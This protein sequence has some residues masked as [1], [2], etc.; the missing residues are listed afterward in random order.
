MDKNKILMRGVIERAEGEESLRLSVSSE[1]PCKNYVHTNN[2]GI[3]ANVILEHSESAIEGAWIKDGIVLRDNH[4]GEVVARGIDCHIAD[5][6]LVCDGIVWGA[7]DR[8]QTI[9]ADVESGVIRDLSIEADY[10]VDDVE[11]AD[12]DLY[13]IRR[14]TPLAAAFVAIP[15]DP[16]VG[17]NREF[18]AEDVKTQEESSPEA[19]C[20]RAKPM[21]NENKEGDALAD[22][23]P[24]V[25][26][27]VDNS[28]EITR[29]EHEQFSI[30]RAIR[31]IV[32]RDPSIAK[33]E[34]KVSD[35]L[36]R[37]MGRPARGLYM[38]LERSFTTAAGNGAGLVET[39]H[40]GND[41]I[42][43]LRDKM[44]LDKL[45]VS[46]LTGLHG[47]CAIPKQTGAMAAYWV[48]EGSAPTASNPV[49]GQV[50]LAPH[51]VGAY[52][53]ITRTLM[54]QAS[55]DADAIVQND[56]FSALA[57]AIQ[58]AALNG[59]GA[60]GQP[61][62]I[63][64]TTGVTTASIATDGAPTYAEL[65]G[66]AG[67]ID[68]WF[69]NGGKWLINNKSFSTLRGTKRFATS[70]GDRTMADIVDG[71]KYVA[72]EPAY[73]SA[74]LAEGSAIF[75][76]WENVVIAMWG[77][78]DLTV[79]PYSLSTSGGLRIV[80]LQDVDVAVRHPEAFVITNKLA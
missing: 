70:G 48:A 54:L 56:I 21:I 17:I 15:A 80:G 78:L 11:E 19:K 67:D 38:P 55:P 29:E 57:L 10:S 72:D 7:G 35:K 51:T 30:L 37:K 4:G 34:H 79:D 32:E 28:A 43:V 14:W 24:V 73:T 1:T 61:T 18:I 66:F 8:A 59:T 20:E 47:N 13:I 45:G 63:L 2:G 52:C 40:L 39:R 31:S 58:D 74:Q 22:A 9:K 60:N 23:V 71:Q 50:S 64:N 16:T 33:L 25:Q 36:A 69:I 3:Y 27:V 53:D 46:Y 65:V 5:A 42:S 76:K 68:E 6:K 77:A 12:D 26:S 44:V 49:I 62:G 41:F 75:G